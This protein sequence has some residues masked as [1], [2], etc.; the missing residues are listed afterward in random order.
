M[1]LIIMILMI[2]IGLSFG[3]FAQ[4][5]MSNDRKSKYTSSLWKK[6]VGKL[7]NR[8]PRAYQANTTDEVISISSSG[9]S[10][11][12]QMIKDPAACEV[13]SFVFDNF[14]FVMLD[15][16]AIVMTYTARQD[17]VCRGQNISSQV[18][19]TVNYVKR[20]GR[21]LEAMYME[22]PMSGQSG[23]IQE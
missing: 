3:A 4:T 15:K 6:R 8:L 21:W 20:D 23:A 5:K 18:R 9:V 13:K 2:G 14:K 22:M 17:G 12:T 10:K 7:E 16:D 11:K 19:A 1:K